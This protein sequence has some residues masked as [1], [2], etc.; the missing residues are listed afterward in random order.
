MNRA[1]WA[2]ILGVL[3]LC[4]A[5]CKAK[6]DD[7]EAIRAGIVKYLSGL[8]GLNVGNM[9]VVVTQ[10]TV[11]GN[12]AQAQVEI[13]AKSG[14]GAGGSMQLAYNLEKRGDEWVVVKSQPTGGSLQHP[15]PGEMPPGGA[16]PPGHPD[17]NGGG[18]QPVHSDLNEM[19]K[20]AQPPAQQP[21]A[22][23]APA[24]GSKP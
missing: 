5:A 3:L 4:T 6:T 22:Q 18:N 10:A 21:P 9:D 19:M 16:M 23:P 11:N 7:K 20:S 15:G 24:T 13:R 1:F 17:V 8:R 14:E 12:T 2:S